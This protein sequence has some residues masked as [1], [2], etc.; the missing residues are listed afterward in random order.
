LLGQHQGENAALA[1]KTLSVWGD[2]RITQQ[3]I[4]EGARQAVW[5]ARMQ[6]LE[7]GAVVGLI[8]CD[9]VWLDG[10]HNPHAA[11]LRLQKEWACKPP[12]VPLLRRLACKQVR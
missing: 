1:A 12:L 8:G 5:P 9:E 3:A 11:K 10:G 4:V 2:T 7:P 6:K